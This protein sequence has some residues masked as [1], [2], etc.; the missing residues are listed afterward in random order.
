MGGTGAEWPTWLMIVHRSSR[1]VGLIK[2][3]PMCE[4]R[5]EKGGM[6][7]F[8]FLRPNVYRDID[9][10]LQ[11]FAPPN[12]RAHAFTRL[13]ALAT[14]FLAATQ[15]CI[16]ELSTPVRSHAIFNASASS[17]W[18]IM[19][20]QVTMKRGVKKKKKKKKK[21]IKKKKKKKKKS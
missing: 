9:A 1:M 12:A 16:H 11:E 14:Q 17:A 15:G 19:H 4:E 13:A 21:G 6:V 10:K 3:A 18:R 2:E 7:S 5:Q 20:S 8:S